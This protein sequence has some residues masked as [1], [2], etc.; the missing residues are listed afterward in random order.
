MYRKQL[1]LALLVGLFLWQRATLGVAQEVTPKE[2]YYGQPS[3][4]A[5][6]WTHYIAVE[7]GF[8]AREG[9][10]QLQTILMGSGATTIQA[11]IAGSIRFANGNLEAM[12]S[13]IFRGGDAVIIGSTLLKPPFG[14]V[15]APSIKNIGGL[16]G[17][18]IGVS[19]PVSG[20]SVFLKKVLSQSGLRPGDYV[21]M[22]IGGTSTRYMSLKQGRID[23]SALSQPFDFRL[24]E[25]GF[26]DLGSVANHLREYEYNG[27]AT[28]RS[29]AKKNTNIVRGFLK[30]R[31]AAHKW[32]YD[33]TN[34]DE[35]IRILTKW[36]RVDPKYAARTYKL[37]IENDRLVSKTVAINKDGFNALLND[38]VE[39]GVIGSQTPSIDNFVDLS[40][41]KQ[42]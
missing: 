42:D 30:A 27:I 25:E 35:A 13:A 5:L 9:M 14:L 31:E 37:W 21:L 36:T 32:I 16:R 22:Q 6:F 17:K 18:T 38:M 10:P 40:F 3:F 29:W 11:L 20:E 33:L 24:I 41:L 1:F 28:T 8:Y 39:R 15:A 12:V 2:L 4:S 7:K 26:T 23:A 19:S 34:R